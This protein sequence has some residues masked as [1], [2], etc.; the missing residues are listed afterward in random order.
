MLQGEKL[1]KFEPK[2]PKIG[3][4]LQNPTLGNSNDPY[5]SLMTIS[6]YIYLKKIWGHAFRPVLGYSGCFKVRNWSNL[7]QNFQHWV[8]GKT[9][10]VQS[11]HLVQVIPVNVVGGTFV[12]NVNLCLWIII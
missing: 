8:R 1:V 7:S 2:L 5:P 12:T 4:N 3:R 10:D 6:G 11:V 9:D